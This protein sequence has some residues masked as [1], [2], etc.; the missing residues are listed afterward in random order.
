MNMLLALIELILLGTGYPRP[1]ANRAGACTAIVA[2]EKWF[3][4]DAGR[5]ATMRIAATDLKY[6]N[7]R[8]VFL[9]HLHS[10][11]TAGLPDLFD[12]SWQFGRKTVPLELYG[13]RGTKQLADAML[14]FF[15]EDIHLRR[16]LLEKHPAAGATI[17]THIVN[18][19]VVYDDGDV[20]VTAFL[21]DHK[22][23]EYAFGYRFESGGKTIVV[24]GDTRPNENLVRF[25]KGA[26]VLVLEAYLPEH[27]AKVDTPEVAA[28]LTRYHTSAIEAG[29]LAARAGVKTLV[30]THLIPGNAD[31]T[32]RERAARAFHGTIIVGRDLVRVAP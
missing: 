29:E 31:E 26:D 1:D 21:V 25:A 12:T 14:Q 3:V 17:R 24:S 19:G 28:R 5:G 6:E 20:K 9:T 8:G 18:E 30:L 11:H 15:A 27:F 13:P 32:F 7:L 16:D 2:G 22:P 4:V 23:V 10:D